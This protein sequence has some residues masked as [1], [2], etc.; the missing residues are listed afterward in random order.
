LH[1]GAQSNLYA[2]LAWTLVHVIE[3]PE[4]LARV[5][6]GDDA[7]LER[8][9]NESIRVAQRSIT[10]REVLRPVDVEVEERT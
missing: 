4:L 5:R 3:D 10:L 9:A 6:A 1:L 7:L 2:A 8:C